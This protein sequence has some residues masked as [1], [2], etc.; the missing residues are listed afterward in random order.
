MLRG[1]DRR[2][3]M[4]LGAGLFWLSVL[5]LLARAGYAIDMKAGR[6]TLASP[7]ASGATPAFTSVNFQ[8]AFNFTPVVAVVPTTDNAGPDSVRIRNISTTGFEMAVAYPDGAPGDNAGMDVHYVAME[9]GVYS[10]AGANV[11]A[12]RVSTSSQQGKNVPGNSWTNISFGSAFSQA[13]TVLTSVQT[14]NNETP[15]DLTTPSRPWLQVAMRNVTSAGMDIALERGETSTG[16]VSSNEEI[17][18]IAFSSGVDASF[19][20]TGG[21]SIRYQ[22]VRSADSVTQACTSVPFNSAFA[23]LP[24]AVASQNSRDGGDG[25]WSKRCSRSTSDLGV[26]IEE[27]TAA[28]NDGNHTTEIVGV[29]AF[30]DGFHSAPAQIGFHLEAGVAS[31]PGYSSTQLNWTSVSFPNSFN[32]TPLVFSLPTDQGSEPAALRLR[33]VSA[34]GFEIAQVEPRPEPGAHTS[35]TVD[36]LAVVPGIHELADGFVIEAGSHT[37]ATTQLAPDGGFPG[38]SGWDS[39]ALQYANF[40]DPVVVT[41][42]QTINNEPGLDPSLPSRP[43]LTAAVENVSAASFDLALERS[44][45]NDGSSVNVAETIAWLAVDAN[46]TTTLNANGGGTV[47]MESRRGT[48]ILG[49]DDGC[50]TTGWLGSYPGAPIAVAA[51]NTR[52]GNNGGWVRRCSINGSAIGLVIDEDRFIDSE[53]NHIGETA[54]IIAVET[55]FEYDYPEPVVTAA[56]L[57]NGQ[58][59]ATAAPGSRNTHR[60]SMT[61]P[62]VVNAW[63]LSLDE[64]LD[65][66][67]GLAM[68]TYSGNPFQ[69]NDDTPATGLSINQ[70]EYSDDGGNT[71][72]YTPAATGV[73]YNVTDFRLSFS[74]SLPPGAS[75]SVDF[76]TGIR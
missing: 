44:E 51:G 45:V 22:T 9:P 8:Q 76:E 66:L 33:N 61:N 59:T 31:I 68:D 28:D 20:D 43:W 71:W 2:S 40:S 50:F 19:N 58:P 75:V 42:I 62:G 67:S 47:T 23:A 4:R 49:Y 30:S 60:I 53:R 17:G 37:T 16:S 34:S 65:G 15:M 3:A 25:G 5:L 29:A 74:G 24:V 13:P 38:V 69:F 64:S 73:D 72:T 14:T 26:L 10:L 39:I 36:Y 27:D 48:G 52:A 55:A 35:M 57:I 54:G 56:R 46:Q 32:S 70:I 41:S 63:T 7:M 11:I 12:G 6:V 21:S 18:Y 1:T